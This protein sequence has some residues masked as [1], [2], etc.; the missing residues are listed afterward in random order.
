MNRTEPDQ[1][2][3]TEDLNRAAREAVLA[4]FE[5]KDIQH[6]DVAK[7]TAAQQLCGHGVTLGKWETDT[8]TRSKTLRNIDLAAR[9][10]SALR[11]RDPDWQDD[12]HSDL[13]TEG[14]L[15]LTRLGLLMRLAPSGGKGHKKTKS[16]KP[17]TVIN[18]MYMEGP[19]LVAQAIHHKA[20]LSTA[21]PG[22][23]RY[24]TEEDLQQLSTN[25]YLSGTIAR[26]DILAARELW[27]DVPVRKP[28]PLVTDPSTQGPQRSPEQKRVPHPPFPDD[29][30]SEIGPRVLWVINEL[31]PNLLRLLERLPEA[32]KQVDWSR[33]PKNIGHR[34]LIPLI[35][36]ELQYE[37]WIDRTGRPLV[38]PFHFRTA[39]GAGSNEGYVDR[40][41][42]PI[43]TWEQVCLLSATL[44]A[45]HAFIALLATAGRV[46]EGGTLKRDC[47]Q[48]HADGAQYVHGR[49]YKL[50][51]ALQGKERT[52]PAPAI[53]ITALGQQARL[54][55]A[56]DWIPLKQ[57]CGGVPT[58]PQF[59][60]QLWVSIGSSPRCGPDADFA[61]KAA[62]MSLAERLDVTSM[63]GDKAVHPHRFRKSAARLAGIALWNSP[64]VL[65]QLLGHKD[66]EMTLQYILSDPDIREEAEKVLRELR[67]MHCSQSLQQVREAMKASR[68]S[69]FGGAGGARMASA[70]IEYEDRET[71]TQSVWTTETAYNLAV[72]YT[73]NGL[74]WRLGIGFICSKLPH[75]A[76]ECRKGAS[77]RGEHGQPLISNC[78]P[79]CEHRCELPDQ[80][81]QARQQRDVEDV[82][83]G[84]LAIANQ[85]CEEGQLLLAAGCL[86]QLDDELAE[87]PALNARYE[88]RPDV[89]AL[90]A[91][92]EPEGED[93]AAHG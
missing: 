27:W 85:A 47:V 30:L 74:G 38:P 53:L 26:L 22:L 59:G 63:P 29:W 90:I 92:L 36:A 57:G 56:W 76:G 68:P 66:I 77:R 86:Q 62:L 78:K 20:A 67:V 79:T 19:A 82:C 88:A 6:L 41:E 54:A 32:L 40:H 81:A 87:W 12:D 84:Y 18:M 11:T 91:A 89:K 24:L 31:G 58:A 13:I 16:L 46:G 33:S 17:S 48:Q 69:P 37:P 50:T 51:G 83:E 44:Q 73:M 75:E 80:I 5:L 43:R 60:D 10:C 61:W 72:E 49:T 65:K 4:R 2:N 42:W 35:V 8:R 34:V 21:N 71:V 1:K 52:W 70:V 7:L 15:T 39:S 64:L 28:L 45:A 93:E 9:I 55:A 23:F 14:V 3:A 25:R